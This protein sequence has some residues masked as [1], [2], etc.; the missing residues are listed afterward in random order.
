V[1]ATDRIRFSDGPLDDI[2]GILCA[3]S[4]RASQYLEQAPALAVLAC[5]K[6]NSHIT[7]GEVDRFTAVVAPEPKLRDVVAKFGAPMAIRKLS[8]SALRA[9]DVAAVEWLARLDPST[10]SQ[11]IPG[12]DG[13]RAWLDGILKWL[14]LVPG[15]KRDRKKFSVAWIAR[16]LAADQ[17]RI[18][19][20]DNVIDFVRRGGRA[21]NERW[22]WAG[23][24][25]AVNRWHAVLND[26]RAIERALQDA[27]RAAS[28]DR[29][30]CKAPLPDKASVD[31]YEFIVLRTPRQIQDE[32][33]AMHHCVASY[34]SHVKRGR[35]AIISV[36]RDG[37]RVATLEISGAGT[38]AQIKTHC[39]GA[40]STAIRQAC[41][42]YALSNWKQEA[43]AA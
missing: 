42:A 33:V 8:A 2:A 43:Q 7:Y 32:G 39:N 16:Q 31:G 18:E 17:G 30:I 29:V 26:T 22:T 3:N 6:F 1:S 15:N 5:G 11:C 28:F 13:Q 24:L 40:P 34:A 23:A 21:L 20:I 14:I 25:E 35:C 27:G 12:A 19:Q 41:A 38:V 9:K 36:G 4:A 37:V 10:L